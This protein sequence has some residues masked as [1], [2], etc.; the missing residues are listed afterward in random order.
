M[1]AR[2]LPRAMHVHDFCQLVSFRCLIWRNHVLLQ[3]E[4]H[5]ILTFCHGDYT[6]IALP[7]P[8]DQFPA[9]S[10]RAVAR[11]AHLPIPADDIPV[12]IHVLDAD[13]DLSCMPNP[14]SV[15]L[16]QDWNLRPSRIRGMRML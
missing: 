14:H 15:V 11:C 16:A 2:G 4:T 3:Q 9:C 6:R 7:H 1:T 12:Y 13:Q 5:Q 10:T 8:G